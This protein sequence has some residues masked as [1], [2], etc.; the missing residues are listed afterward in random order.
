MQLNMSAFDLGEVLGEVAANFEILA[1]RL[2]V[3]IKLETGRDITVRADEA[4]IRQVIHNLLG[5]ALQHT[6]PGGRV[7]VRTAGEG[8]VRVEIADTGSG[9]AGEDLPH[10][11]DRFYKADSPEKKRAGGTGLG[12]SI[13]RGIFET[14]G[15]A[16]GVDSVVGEGTVFWYEMERMK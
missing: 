3:E 6:P 2:D 9:I 8:P 11:W 1:T 4:R 10:I 15:F 13:V 12:L 14:H 7:T 5:N 16:Y